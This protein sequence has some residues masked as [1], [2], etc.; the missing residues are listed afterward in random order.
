MPGTVFLGQS[1]VHHHITII[2][3]T[4]LRTKVGLGIII[5]V[6]SLSVHWHKRFAQMTTMIPRDKLALQHVQHA[7]Y[8]RHKLHRSPHQSSSLQSM[9]RSLRRGIIFTAQETTE[10]SPIY[11]SA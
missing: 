2:V 9:S 4:R 8:F 6:V 1:L 3:F 10:Q 7:P 5:T 11:L